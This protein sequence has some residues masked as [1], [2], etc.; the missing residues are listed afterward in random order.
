MGRRE[1][2]ELKHKE[3]SQSQRTGKEIKAEDKLGGQ[4]RDNSKREE[5]KRIKEIREKT[6]SRKKKWKRK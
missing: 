3:R 6:M 4:E 5:L 2:C 1:N